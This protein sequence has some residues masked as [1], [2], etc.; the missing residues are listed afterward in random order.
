LKKPKKKLIIFIICS[1]IFF[2]FFIIIVI[3]LI[4]TNGKLKIKM[5]KEDGRK[6]IKIDEFA[7]FE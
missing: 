5:I 3:L 6:M 2:F 4:F 7:E 1:S